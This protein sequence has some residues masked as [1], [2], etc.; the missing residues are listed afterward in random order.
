[1]CTLY[2]YHTGK[3]SESDRS[4]RNQNTNCADKPLFEHHSDNWVGGVLGSIG[5]RFV[6]CAPRWSRGQIRPGG[7]EQ[8]VPLINGLCYYFNKESMFKSWTFENQGSEVNIK[9]PADHR[10]VPFFNRG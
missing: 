7:Q 4:T 2:A 8:L 9:R 6:A 1:M 10:L 3:C 5:N